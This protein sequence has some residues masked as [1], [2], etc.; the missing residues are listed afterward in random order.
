[1]AIATYPP[2]RLTR[3]KVLDLCCGT[4]GFLV[5]YITYLREKIRRIEQA[6]GGG[7]EEIRERV[8]SRVKDLCSHNLFGTD[9]NPFLVRTCQMNMVMH[10][11]G[12][13]N[14]FQG[15]SLVFPGEWQDARA[16]ELV[17]H[18]KFDLVITNPPFGANAT[19]D[20]PPPPLTIRVAWL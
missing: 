16:A 12:S 5:S 10:G 2:Q 18:G 20:D 19:I 9:I 4:G 6:K 17:P 15:D 3:L 1:M 14:I 7:D 13:A 11:D 8:V